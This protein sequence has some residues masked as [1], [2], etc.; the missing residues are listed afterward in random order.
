MTATA[1][2]RNWRARVTGWIVFHG[3]QLG[4]LPEN[5]VNWSALPGRAHKVIVPLADELRSAAEK[6]T[7]NGDARAVRAVERIINRR[8]WN[9]LTPLA[10]RELGKYQ[11]LNFDP[12]ASPESTREWCARLDREL[13]QSAAAMAIT[14]QRRTHTG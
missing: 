1:Q 12:Y 7:E 14:Q 4:M 2:P 13:E 3:K 8:I 5:A 10:G 11:Q 9:A 6:A